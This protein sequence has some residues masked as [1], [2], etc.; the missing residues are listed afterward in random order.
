METSLLLIRHAETVWNK[1]GRMQGSQDSPLSEAGTHEAEALGRRLRG[2]RLDA[3]YSSDL[4]RCVRTA[5][6][7][8]D[9]AGFQFRLMPELRERSLGDWE[10]GVWRQIAAADPEAARLYKETADYRPPN[11][12]TFFDLQNRVFGALQDIANAHPGRRVAVFTS[13]GSIRAGIF[14]AMKLPAE[15]W[16]RF[17][18]WN[19]G[20]SRLDF[21]KGIWKLVKFNDVAHLPGTGNGH[22]VF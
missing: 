15:Q 8:L 6:I 21:H 9:G 4:A 22:A 2:L 10:G 18:T 7:A 12:E 1:E 11:G 20:I 16:G 13:G 5:R 14:A 19:T 3:V 17:A